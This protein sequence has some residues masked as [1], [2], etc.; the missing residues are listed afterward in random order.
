MPRAEPHLP[1]V[2]GCARRGVVTPLGLGLADDLLW[3]GYQSTT[4]LRDQAQQDT[5]DGLTRTF[6]ATCCWWA[7][8]VP[9]HGPPDWSPWSTPHT[10]RLL[11][12]Q[13]FL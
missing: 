5:G 13:Y 10:G 9:L 6:G 7:A 12:T 4:E 1:R 3:G 11:W 8:W 2:M